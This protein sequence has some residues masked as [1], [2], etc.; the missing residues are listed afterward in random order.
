MR[1]TLVG[2]TLATCLVTFIPPAFA[3]SG[4][5]PVVSHVPAQG[6]RDGAHHVVIDG[7]RLWYR[8]AGSA[9]PERPPVI[10]LHGGPG[11]FSHDFAVLAG[12][13]LEPS[14]RMVY[15]DQR[16][17]GR[18]ERPWTGDYSMD[19]LVED[20]EGLRR[21]L[22]VPQVA[23]MG[24]SFGGALAL[25]YAAKYPEH[26]SHLVLVAGLSDVA[27]SGRSMCKRLAQTN[28]NAYALA[29]ADSADRARADG[30][31]AM[32]ALRGNE[33][34]VFWKANMYP[35]SS[36]R[37]LRDSVMAASGL[38]NTGELQRALFASGLAEY[39][40]AAHDRLTMPVLVIAGQHD[41]QIGVESQ[42]ALARQLPNAKLL[43][44]ERGG[45]HLYLDESERFARDVTRFLAT[46]SAGVKPR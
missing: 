44:Y 36:V 35:D 43:V 34:E 46:S 7:V 15:L 37:M 17:S 10:Y 9:A 42:Q 5:N 8:V 39:R 18:S 33:R 25:E 24:H 6:L 14:L 40:F 31:N 22:G 12:P 13:R 29:V 45:H 30:C 38:R 3:Q 4:A 1:H 26:V 23:L 20:L 28:P 2:A 41:Y 11:G 19:R 21:V 27:F 16:G 32:R